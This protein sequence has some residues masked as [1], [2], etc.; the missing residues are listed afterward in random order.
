ML[1]LGL[2]AQCGSQCDGISGGITT[3]QWKVRT[4]FPVYVVALSAY[5]G[6]R[7]VQRL[8]GAV[9]APPTT[10]IATALHLTS[11][12]GSSQLAH[13]QAGFCSWSSRGW[14]WWL[15]PWT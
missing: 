9:T 11:D 3:Q 10:T 15:C 5:I 8:P 14:A 13:V 1:H 12:E 2:S 7:L 4:S 6:E